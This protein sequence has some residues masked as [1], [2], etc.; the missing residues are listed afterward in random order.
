MTS[1]QSITLNSDTVTLDKRDHKRVY[2]A[3]KYTREFATGEHITLDGDNV[4][5]ERVDMQHVTS[6]SNDNERLRE[7][8]AELETELADYA[9]LA[10]HDQQLIDM[11]KLNA[12]CCEAEID[13]LT[14]ELDNHVHYTRYDRVSNDASYLEQFDAK[15]MQG[16]EAIADFNRE[17]SND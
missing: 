14:D 11:M 2:Q 16:A 17:Q 13:R 1:Q 9:E 5:S 15:H 12:S 4:T 8:I 6:W 7:R 10:F 3:P